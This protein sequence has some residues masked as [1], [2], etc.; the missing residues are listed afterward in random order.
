MALA[1][2]PPYGAQGLYL[3]RTIAHLVKEAV[4]QIPSLVLPTF[5]MLIAK[6][7]A[8][9]SVY[10]HIGRK[11]RGESRYILDVSSE[12]CNSPF[13]TLLMYEEHV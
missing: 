11:M 13:A 7:I 6:Y 1:A 9:T 3:P 12:V 4:I 5:Q 10:Q 8:C 2:Q